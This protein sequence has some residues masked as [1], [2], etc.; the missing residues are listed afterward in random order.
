MQDPEHPDPIE[1]VTGQLSDWTVRLALFTI[2]TLGLVVL[3][4]T[5][6]SEPEGWQ[7]VNQTVLQVRAV[8]D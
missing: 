8:T 1:P 5:G 3:F 2:L 7:D 4:S 6:Y